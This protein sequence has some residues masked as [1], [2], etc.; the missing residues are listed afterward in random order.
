MT[1]TTSGARTKR[2]ELLGAGSLVQVGTVG[3]AD[4]KRKPACAVARPPC[5]DQEPPRRELAM[6]RHPRGDSEDCGKFVSARS[7]PSH[8][9]RRN[10]SAAFEDVDRVVHRRFFVNEGVSLAESTTGVNRLRSASIY[11]HEPLARRS[12]G[13]N[14]RLMRGGLTA[15]WRILATL[16]ALVGLVAPAIAQTPT[17]ESAQATLNLSAVLKAAA[18]RSRAVCAGGC[19]ARKPIWTARIP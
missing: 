18:R 2:R 4:V 3:E 5:E 15:T 10:R 1:A 12:I 9:R 17:S 13:V 7:G 14:F 19:S 16:V 8:H 6:I 11:G